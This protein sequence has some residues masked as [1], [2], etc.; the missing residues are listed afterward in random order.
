MWQLVDLIFQVLTSSSKL[1]LLKMLKLISIDPAEL[2]VL[3]A[4]V[5]VLLFTRT[6]KLA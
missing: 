6:N 5:L 4:L 1:S 3:A 2:H